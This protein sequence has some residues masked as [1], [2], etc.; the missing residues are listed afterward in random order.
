MATGA[1][2]GWGV[3]RPSPRLL[4]LALT[5][6]AC[7]AGAATLTPPLHA[8]DPYRPAT[9]TGASAAVEAL[10]MT[11][12]PAPVVSAEPTPPPTPVPTAIPTLAPTPRPTAKPTPPPPTAPPAPPR[13]RLVSRDGRL[14]TG[15][16]TYSDCSG[17]TPLTHSSAA[18]DTCVT[19]VTYFVGHNPGVFTPLFSETV[20]SII[21]WYDGAGH[22]HPLRVVATR[23]WY[24]AD[25]VPP[26]VSGAV[27][28]QFQT[29]EVSDGSKDLIL[30]AVPA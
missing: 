6:S 22:A 7:A 15:V 23:N 19:D 9:A 17:N 21:T 8:V 2:Y 3:R 26:P 11:A 25:G 30:D 29:C 28:A 16:T 14:N 20:G 13:N 10:E 24:R 1:P 12:R 4:L 18:I 5:G 27:V